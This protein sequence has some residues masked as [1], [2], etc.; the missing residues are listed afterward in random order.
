MVKKMFYLS[1]FLVLVKSSNEL[2]GPLDSVWTGGELLLHGL[3][4]SR[5]NDLF[6]FTQREKMTL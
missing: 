2:C 3:D 4:L 1:L 6:A 5:V